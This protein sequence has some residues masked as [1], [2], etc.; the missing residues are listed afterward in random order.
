MMKNLLL[1]ISTAICVN[2]YAMDTMIDSPHTEKSTKKRKLSPSDNTRKQ[3]FSITPKK[4]PLIEEIER[5]TKKSKQ[6]LTENDR[7]QTYSPPPK[8]RLPAE[9]EAPFDKI[10]LDNLLDVRVKLLSVEI[11]K[12]KDSLKLIREELQEK[13]LEAKAL[14]QRENDYTHA[15]KLA[16]LIVSTLN[17]D[18]SANL[19]LTNL[20]PALKSK[21][22]D[23]VVNA[24]LAIVASGALENHINQ[25]IEAI[26]KTIEGINCKELAE[27]RDNIRDITKDIS[28]KDEP[29]SLEKYS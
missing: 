20:Y 24:S 11:E 1:L 16:G 3:T 2:S 14:A 5:P 22:E 8:K 15:S 23:I 6:S 19:V 10:K 28:I 18:K 9:E 27:A 4:Q 13:L 7:K 25:F 26:E 29:I 12:A 17:L 21:Q